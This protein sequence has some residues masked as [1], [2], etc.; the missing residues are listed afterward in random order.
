MTRSDIATPAQRSRILEMAY[1][2]R[3]QA[4]IAV[5]LGLS[6]PAV[7][8]VVSAAQNNGSG[9]DALAVAVGRS[10]ALG[11]PSTPP[12]PAHRGPFLGVH[13]GR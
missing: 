2:G 11:S 6:I 3:S 13:D 1:N 12:V 8:R 9:R 10:S 7:A 5:A 4:R